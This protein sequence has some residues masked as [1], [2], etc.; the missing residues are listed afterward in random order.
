MEK[1]N[2]LNFQYFPSII[3]HPI[4]IDENTL[5][6][7]SYS[8]KYGSLITTRPS[9]FGEIDNATRYLKSGKKLGIFSTKR[10][11]KLLDIRYIA[12]IIND[13]ILLRKSN[14]F[15]TIIKGYMT[16]SLSYG[17]VSLYKQ[18][19]L[20][21]RRYS[22]SLNTD[23]K[24]QKMV[25]YYNDFESKQTKELFQNPLELQGI[26]IGEINNDVEST[27]ILKEIFRDFFDGFICP[28]IFSPYFDENNIPNEILLFNPLDSI[29][30]IDSIPSNSY[31]IN[32]TEILVK[33][34][35][36]L[37]TVPYFMK[38]DEGTYFQ[39]GGKKSSMDYIYE[40]NLLIHDYYGKI[41]NKIIL[42]NLKKQGHEFKK[43]MLAYKIKLLHN[44]DNMFQK[45][46]RINNKK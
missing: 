14:D 26:R 45:N 15:E 1:Y 42:N 23:T 25:E 38:T 46:T 16:L 34:N 12:Q 37:F 5:F 24:Y 32:I 21:K 28:T 17:L 4:I 33:N 29:I 44:E 30:E 41:D 6:F 2:I 20:Y 22:T 31:S 36:D 7:K 39:H 13:L 3:G 19:N 11:L 27:F 35:I 40:K 8:T 9:Y 18:L 10:K 43:N